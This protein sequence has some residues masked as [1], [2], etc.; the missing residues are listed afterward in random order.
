MSRIGFTG[1]PLAHVICPAVSEGLRAMLLITAYPTAMW[2][3]AVRVRAFQCRAFMGVSAGF[4]TDVD[5]NT[6]A[7]WLDRSPCRSYCL[8]SL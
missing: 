6:R 5:N 8:I 7:R 4:G 2:S 1:T 3:V